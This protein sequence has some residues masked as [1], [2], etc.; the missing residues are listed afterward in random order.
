MSTTIIATRLKALREQRG[1]SQ[2]QLARSLGFKNRQTLQAIESGERKVAADELVRA[3]EVF[4]VPLDTFTDPFLLLG[5]G[6]FSWRQSGV[7]GSDLDAY[8]RTAGGLV[9]AYRTLA[10]MVGRPPR[11]IRPSL[12]L[13]KTS[14]YEDAAAA[15]ERFAAEY[16]LGEVPARRLAEVMERELGILTLMVDP[17]DGVSGAACRLPD[18]DAVLINRNEVPG[19]RHFDLAHE[20]FH[21]LTW[22]AMPPGHVEDVEDVAPR[23]RSRVEQLADNF[24][25]AVLMPADVVAPLAAWAE[26]TG[27]GLIDRLNAAADALGVSAVAL[28]WRLVSLGYLTR[29]ARRALPEERLRHNGRDVP[30]DEATPPLFSRTFV[31]VIALAIDDGRVSVRRA[32]RLVG[33]S[34]DELA[35]LCKLY[36]VAVPDVL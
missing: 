15:G 20:L 10:P 5:E 26:L 27:D 7:S 13:D 4:R 18:L 33:L 9:A 12:A 19:R 31:E 11:L 24:A 30:R 29:S 3:G 22:E 23:R 14:T 16:E 36:D 21:I 2:E 6:A 8:E 32:E 28:G 34:G 25:S 1:L 17:I 35:D